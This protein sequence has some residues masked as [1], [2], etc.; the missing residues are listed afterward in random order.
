M[1]Q[2]SRTIQTNKSLNVAEIINHEIETVRRAWRLT[3][4]EA[5]YREPRWFKAAASAATKAGRLPKRGYGGS[6][7]GQLH[8]AGFHQALDHM[9]VVRVDGERFVILEPYECSCS[10][11]TARRIAKELAALLGCDAWVRVTESHRDRTT[12]VK[13][14]KRAVDRCLNQQ[15][16]RSSKRKRLDCQFGPYEMGPVFGE[17]IV[18][19]ADS[20]HFMKTDCNVPQ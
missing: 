3:P 15:I 10:M 5:S 13:P 11:D 20:S 19:L 12:H 8:A 7:I 9:A 2:A 16:G 6:V 14:T 17:V 4:P 18:S 1:K